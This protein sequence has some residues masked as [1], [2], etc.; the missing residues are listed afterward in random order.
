MGSNVILF[1]WNRPQTGR[2]KMSGEHFGDFVDYLGGL[3]KQGDIDG[4]DIVFLEPHGGDLNGFFLIRG[5]AESLD[6]VIT[7]SAWSDHMV[8]ATLHLE[9]PGY[10]RGFT[11]DK[12]MDRMQLWTS[13]IPG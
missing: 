4:F 13:N 7:S 11:G 8:R 5:S 12:V 2:E 10:I 9:S 6:R 3:Q 1:G